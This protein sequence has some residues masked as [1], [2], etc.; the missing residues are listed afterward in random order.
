MNI[1]DSQKG[2]LHPITNIFLEI[3]HI[4][5]KLGFIVAEGPEVETEWYNFDALGTA[6]DHSSRDMQDT[7]WLKETGPKG[8][9]LLPRT[10]TSSVQVR[11]AQ[12]H[13]PP[14]K[15]IAP[16]K[17]FRN[18]ASDAT[19]ESEF[20]QLE[21]M[22]V[23]E[24]VSL[25]DLKSTLEFFA[26]EFFGPDSEI[27]FRPSYFPFVEPGLEVDVKFKGKW[28]EVLGAGLVH[29]KVLEAS[30]IDSSKWQGFAFGMGVDRL[31]MLRY[32]IPDI[33]FLYSGDLR[34]VDQF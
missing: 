21:G 28:L 13:K 32:G 15:I 19:H 20:Y 4:F 6:K 16:G 17:V 34:V 9:R 29:P 22:L 24:K 27:R 11:F 14:F 5:S 23:A 2:H 7:F 18:E 10:H 1:Q 26:K 3:Q 33:R 12:S 8:D 25:V 31:V 30:G